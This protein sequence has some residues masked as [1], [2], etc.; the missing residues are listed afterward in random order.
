MERKLGS[1]NSKGNK[2]SSYHSDSCV[3]NRDKGCK[4]RKQLSITRFH[5]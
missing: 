3:T 4:F 1:E 2:K 5:H